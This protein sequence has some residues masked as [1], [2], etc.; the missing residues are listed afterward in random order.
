MLDMGFIDDIEKIVAA[1]QVRQTMLFSATLDGVVG[2][3]ARRITTD[4]L[5]IKSRVRRPSTKHS[6]TCTFRRR[7]LFKESFARSFVTRSIFGSS[8]CFQRLNA[9]QIRLPIASISR[10]RCCCFTAIYQ[11]ARNHYARLFASR[12]SSC[13]GCDRRRRT[14]Y[15]RSGIARLQ[16]RFAKIPRDY[17]HRIGRTGR[18]GRKGLAVSLVNHAESINVKRIERFTKQ[19]IPVDVIGEAS[20]R[21]RLRQPAHQLA[22]LAVWKPG[23]KRKTGQQ[24]RQSNPANA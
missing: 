20:S 8:G 24:F 12:S 2:N 10:L 16:L 21:K 18:A 9:M 19:L 14:W 11:G 15:R 13:V 1:T 23:D 4:P 5:I 6:T 7:P 17:V 22:N 3:M